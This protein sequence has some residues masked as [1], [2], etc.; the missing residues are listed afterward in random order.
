M[1][2]IFLMVSILFIALSLLCVLLANFSLKEEDN[3]QEK[4]Y[5]PSRSK[6]IK[7]HSISPVLAACRRRNT[8]LDPHFGRQSGGLHCINVIPAKT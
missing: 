7:D 3:V 6:R 4:E 1:L 2:I 8:G 5:L